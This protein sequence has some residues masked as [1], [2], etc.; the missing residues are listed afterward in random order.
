MLPTR[1]FEQLNTLIQNAKN[2]KDLKIVVQKNYH[3]MDNVFF[4]TA[5]NI[6]AK[7]LKDK[8]L[9]KE[10]SLIW[11]NNRNLRPRDIAGLIYLCGK[12]NFIDSEFL[13]SLYQLA[14]SNITEFNDQSIANI[15]WSIANLQYYTHSFLELIKKECIKKINSFNVQSLSNTIWAL[16]KM[17]LYEQLLFEI[18]S[19]EVHRNFSHFTPQHLSNIF[20]TYAQLPITD[21]KT[22]NLLINGLIDKVQQLN[23]IEVSIVWLSLA[24]I[25]IH[26]PIF[27]NHLINTIDTTYINTNVI[28]NIFWAC[29]VLNTQNKKVF[30]ILIDLTKKLITSFN[31]QEITNVIWSLAKFNIFEPSFFDILFNEIMK[32]IKSFEARHIANIIWSLGTLVKYNY[33]FF[34]I[35]INEFITKIN[36]ANNQDISNIIWA[37]GN[38]GYKDAN[39]VTIFAEEVKKR[40]EFSTQM[41]ANIYLGFGKINFY[42]IE[43]FTGMNN[44]AVKL[45]ESF[46]NQELSNILMSYSFLKKYD[47]YFFKF[48]LLEIKKRHKILDITNISFIF[49]SF[50]ILQI[51][52][53]LPFFLDKLNNNYME[54]TTI[55]KINFLWSQ[56]ILDLPKNAELNFLIANEIFKDNIDSKDK[57]KILQVYYSGINIPEELVNQCKIGFYLN[58]P[59]IS[60]YQKEISEIFTK[61]NI[62]FQIEKQF[63]YTTVD[64]YLDDYDL[65]IE[66]DGPH[67]FLTKD[68]LN[69]TTILRNKIYLRNSIKFIAIP[70]F[71]LDKLNQYEK[72]KFILSI[73]T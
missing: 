64:F 4:N 9:F 25:K 27:F 12:M 21:E 32:K 68:K 17:E 40:I 16:G 42:E 58:T 66:I 28:S 65:I 46:N 44:Q 72:E 15:L 24:R 63:E 67:H 61:N 38:L 10:I 34:Q 57:T 13:N 47:E 55:G 48:L 2:P 6:A 53:M 20:W 1:Q 35:L 62:K 33:T 3:I 54:L 14:S 18:I 29:A 69:G 51:D 11:C 5:T 26:I 60:N 8:D 23:F 31:Q 22:I 52:D 50:A 41:L 49:K 19:K 56:A 59:L 37:F 30:D 7:K 36:T 71:E 70:Y 45:L 43:L 73:I 39:I